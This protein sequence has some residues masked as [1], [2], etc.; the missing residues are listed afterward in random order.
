MPGTEK[1]AA[2]LQTSGLPV[3]MARG[4]AKG[5]TNDVFLTFLFPEMHIPLNACLCTMAH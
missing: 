2:V 3:T 5:G 1:A 4:M